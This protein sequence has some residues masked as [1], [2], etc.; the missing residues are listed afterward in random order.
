MQCFVESCMGVV[1]TGSMKRLDLGKKHLVD[2]TMVRTGGP[3]YALSLACKTGRDPL[4]LPSTFHVALLTTK[5]FTKRGD[6]ATVT[7]LYTD[8]FHAVA[9]HHPRHV[10]RHLGWGDAEICQ[11]SQ[12]LPHFSSLIEL[13]LSGN[14]IGFNGAKFLVPA[15]MNLSALACI[16]LD[17][18]KLGSAGAMAFVPLVYSSIVLTHLDLS[19]NGVD[20]QAGDRSQTPDSHLQYSLFQ[21][22]LSGIPNC[23][24]R[25][26][27]RSAMHA[28]HCAWSD[29]RTRASYPRAT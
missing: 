14:S 17:N 6:A 15:C 9:P 23:A 29:V 13:T 16:Q 1:L 25:R 11:F 22:S 24:G 19:E 5:R 2:P 20:Q 3:Y 21:Y 4:I 8:F 27:T 28:I 7:Q 10:L 18:N 12:A 26:A